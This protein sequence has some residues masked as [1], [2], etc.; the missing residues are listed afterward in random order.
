MY[1]IHNTAYCKYAN[2]LICRRP[3]CKTSI[4]VDPRLV[5]NAYLSVHVLMDDELIVS[6]NTFL[7]VTLRRTNDYISRTL[8]FFSIL[9]NRTNCIAFQI[10]L[11][12]HPD[13]F[14]LFRDVDVAGVLVG[15]ILVFIVCH[16]FKFF[17]N[18]Y[19]FYIM[20]SGKRLLTYYPNT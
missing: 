17:V 9:Y 1:Y 7:G 4:G 13:F 3:H 8:L 2:G 14:L 15:I 6:V 20:H 10:K 18:I 19:E 12:I 11:P 5:V 16:S